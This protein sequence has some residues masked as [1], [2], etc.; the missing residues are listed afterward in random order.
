MPQKILVQLPDYLLLKLIQN[1]ND[2]QKRSK[3]SDFGQ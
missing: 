2:A 3:M 1:K